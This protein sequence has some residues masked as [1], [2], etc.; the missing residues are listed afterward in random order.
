MAVKSKKDAC[1][2]SAVDSCSIESLVTVDERGQMVLSKAIRDKAGIKPG[3]KLAVAAWEK[4]GKV[5]CITL[6]KAEQFASMV[7]DILGPMINSKIGK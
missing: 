1:C 5:C 3:D 4:D 7:K 2:G 6:I